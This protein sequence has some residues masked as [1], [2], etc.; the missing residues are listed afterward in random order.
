MTCQDRWAG[1]LGLELGLQG[2]TR[3]RSQPWGRSRQV[4]GRPCC[5]PRGWTP[6]D[7]A[8][9]GSH[10]A[11]GLSD[12]LS[13]TPCRLPPSTGLMPP[14]APAQV[15]QQVT[16]PTTLPVTSA[17]SFPPR[18][19][20]SAAIPTSR[21][22]EF[23]GAAGWLG[24]SSPHAGALSA[25]V[26][27][28]A[29]ARALW[30]ALRLPGSG[31]RAVPGALWAGQ[32][33]VNVSTSRPARTQLCS[34]LLWG[35]CACASLA[36]AHFAAVAV[37]CARL[38]VCSCVRQCLQRLSPCACDCLFQRQRP[39]VGAGVGLPGRDPSAAAPAQVF[40]VSGEALG[41]GEPLFGSSVP[42]IHSL[43]D[44]V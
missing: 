11:L 34:G 28:S 25:W 40:V 27:V 10:T 26:Y 12:F 33:V 15:G 6:A 41:L 7:L 36:P 38:W 1:T 5:C 21:L 4:R 14:V 29:S 43:T 32:R 20:R 44:S 35:L 39:P 8:W 17:G 31:G 37:R 3:L 24:W 2:E 18:C 23:P 9:G 16:V 42:F 13:P 22:P 30:G 19:G